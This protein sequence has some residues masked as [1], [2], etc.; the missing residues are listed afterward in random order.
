MIMPTEEIIRE[1]RLAGNKREKVKILADLNC[2]S[3]E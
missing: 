1:Y 2:V 3:N